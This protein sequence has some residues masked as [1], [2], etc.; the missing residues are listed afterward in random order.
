[1]NI[2]AL[3]DM[4]AQVLHT[5]GQRHVE[6]LKR[7]LDEMDKRDTGRLR[8]SIRFTVGELMLQIDLVDYARFV[9]YG[10]G[11]GRFPPV[12]AI[13]GWVER[14]GLTIAGSGAPLETQQRQL[15]YLIGRKI[16]T[17]GIDPSPFIDDLPIDEI[18]DELVEVVSDWIVANL[19]E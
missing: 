12:D 15:T 6:Q 18:E 11:P 8:A 10:R 5:W 2:D 1:M 7:N 17:E 14:K 4:I 9:H 13:R 3:K 19:F 16:A